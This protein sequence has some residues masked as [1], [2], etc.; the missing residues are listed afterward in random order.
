MIAGGLQ[1]AAL[2]GPERYRIWPR[3]LGVLLQHRDQRHKQGSILQSSKPA[4]NFYDEFS[5]SKV[6][7]LFKNN[8][9]KFV[10][11]TLKQ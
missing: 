5:S 11:D 1:F 7:K 8:K 4:E 2:S 9:S 3:R 6:K 10:S